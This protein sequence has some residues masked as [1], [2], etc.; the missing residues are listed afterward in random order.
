MS[1]PSAKSACNPKKNVT[2]NNETTP[3][4]NTP[5]ISLDPEYDFTVKREIKI[6]IVIINI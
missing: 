1:N 6:T 4:Y 5:T 2:V 3:I